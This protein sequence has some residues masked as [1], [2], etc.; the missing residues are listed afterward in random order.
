MRGGPVPDRME[1]VGPTTQAFVTFLVVPEDRALLEVVDSL[2]RRSAEGGAD[3][4][5]E[6]LRSLNDL[7][8]GARIYHVRAT[9]IVEALPG[10][11]SE[12]GFVVSLGK[13]ANLVRMLLGIADS[14]REVQTYRKERIILGREK[15]DLAVSFV[16]NNLILS[17]DPQ[18][19]RV[20][21][22]RLKRA[23]GTAEPS[24]R[25]QAMMRDL[26]TKQDLPGY[27]ALI[28]EKTSLAS[29]W[30]MVTGAPEGSEIA[31]PGSF[32]GAGFR[33]GLASAD[34]LRGDGFFY[35]EDEEAAAG[36]LPQLE[37]ALRRVFAH[38][39]LKS[40]VGV[41]QEGSRLRV[42]VEAQ[43]IQRALDHYF[44]RVR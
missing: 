25:L 15:H 30:R 3:R 35:F 16:G 23:A 33:F 32:E 44:D 9:A 20:L 24:E 13:M 39:R 11:E 27:A 43:G 8:S 18:T 28:N 7:I 6:W 1:L 31:L 34:S 14:E 40:K 2:R 26:E 37:T 38:F 42:S 19:I 29:I 5:A 22:D 10:G 17:R 4:R 41:E 12:V 21:I 36:A